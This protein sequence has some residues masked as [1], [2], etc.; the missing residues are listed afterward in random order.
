MSTD[1][2]QN[3]VKD[4]LV[5]IRSLRAEVAALKG[6][7][8]EPIA[9]VGVGCH[10]P[11]GAH[12]AEQFWQLL[13]D[14]V[15]AIS[16]LPAD[17]W[18]REAFYSPDPETPGKM[19]VRH[20][21]FIDDLATFDT[22][23]FA[24]SPREALSLDPQ[25][26]LMLRVTWEALEHAG[27]PAD[28]LRGSCTGVY[29]GTVSGEYAHRQMHHAAFDSISPY[30]LTGND[31][32]FLAGRIAHFLG[33]QGPTMVTAT[34]CSSSL[35]TVHLACQALRAG[36]CDLALAGGVSLIMDPAVNV[37]LSKMHALSPDGRCK[38]FDAAADGYGRGEGCGVVVLKRLSDAVADGDHI[39]ASLLGSA[40]N[41]DGASAGLTVPSG[42]AQVAL[43]RRVLEVGGVA[44]DEVGYVEAHG[45]G[46]ALGDPI[47]AQSIAQALGSDRSFPL[48]IGSVKTNIGHL[49]AAAGV[50]GLIKAALAVHHG[51]LPRHLHFEAPS[52]HIDWAHLPLRVPTELTPWPACYARRIAGVSSF[53]LSGVNAHVL[54]EAPVPAEAPGASDQRPSHLLPLSA[55]S[56]EALEAQRLQWADY[57]ANCPDS[58]LADVCFTAH[59]GRVHFPHRLAVVAAAAEEARAGLIG[60]VPSS[61]R[62]APRIA[63]LFPGEGPQQVRMGEELY[64]SQPIFRAVLD[65]C[66]A[67]LRRDFDTPLLD[68]LYTASG[69][70][71]P[72]ALDR[73]AAPALVALECALVELWR[74]WGIVPHAV[75]GHGVGEI[76]AAYAAGVFG[77]EEA[78]V[79]AATRARL[80]DETPS[81]GCQYAVEASEEQVAALLRQTGAAD[82]WLAS[83]NGPRSVEI[84]GAR[85][86]VGRVIADWAGLGLQATPVASHAFHSPLATRVADRFE[87]VAASLEHARPEVSLI[88]SLTGQVADD[89]LFSPGYWRQALVQPMRFWQGMLSL[90][91]L[92]IDAFVELGP[93]PVLLPLGRQCLPPPAAGDCLWLPALRSGDDWRQSLDSLGQ[94]YTR[95]ASVD[96]Q[97]FQRE[98]R[99]ARRRLA[100]PTY[101]FQ[102]D[103]YWSVG[104]E[105]ASEDRALPVASTGGAR[106]GSRLLAELQ[107]LAVAERGQVILQGL[108]R[109]V[110]L[111]LGRETLVA[112][113]CTLLELGVDSLMAAELRNWIRHEL[114]LKLGLSELLSAVTLD[115]LARTMV[116]RLCDAPQ[117]SDAEPAEGATPRDRLCPLSHGQEALW[118]VH[119]SDPLSPAYNVGVAVRLRAAL[120]VQVLR[121]AC[122]VLVR[123][124][125]A[126]R[127]TFLA[128][129]GEPFQ[130]VQESVPLHLTETD[131]RS[132]GV[133][134]LR[135]A[136]AVAYREPFDLATGPLLRLHLYRRADEYVLLFVLHHIVC[137]ALSVWSLL[138]EL[139]TVYAGCHGGAP[140]TAARLSP[141]YS[142]YVRWER[143]LLAGEEGE[144]LWSFWEQRLSGELPVL[145]LPADYPR[146]PVQ[147]LH[148]ASHIMIV[149]EELTEGLRALSRA[150]HTTLY[151]T[152][153][154]AFLTLLHRYTAQDDIIV[155]TAT[156]GRPDA[157]AGVFGY[158]ANPV[159]IRADL[160]GDPRFATFLGQVRETVL[161]AVGHQQFPFALLVERLQPRRDASRSPVFQADFALQRPPPAYRPGLQRDERDDGGII[162]GDFAVP[163]EEGQFDVSLH[164]IEGSQTLSAAFKYNADLFAPESIAGLADSYLALLEGIVKAPG[165][166]VSRL[167][168]LSE[169]QRQRLLFGYNN[170][171]ETYPDAC[172]PQLFEQQVARTPQAVAVELFR[173]GAADGER[174]AVM[175]YQELEMR[176]N[177]LARHLQSLG[178]GPEALV[179]VCLERSFN[180]VVA[181][182]GVLKAGGA[183]VPLDPTYPSE[184]LAFMMR[185]ARMSVLLT[186]ATLATSLPDL[187]GVATVRLDWDWPLIVIQPRTRPDCHLQPHHLA[188]VIYTS[189][190]TGQPKGTLITHSGFSNYLNWCIRYYRVAEGSG[191]PVNSA[192]GFDAT[193]TSMF[194][195]LLTGG[196]V[197][198]LPEEEAIEAL[199]DLLIAHRG[200]SLIKITPAHLEMLNQL[201]PADQCAGRAHSFVIGG[202]A[203]R[204]D[205]LTFWQSNAP[206]TRLINEYG[207]TETVVGCCIHDVPGPLT[208]SVPIGRP[209]AN[210]QLYVLDPH[211]QLVPPGVIG[212]LYIGGA[213]VARGYLNRPELTA[214]RFIADPFRS[215]AGGRLY[216]TGDLVRHLPDG[217]L[218]YLGRADTQVKMRGYRIELGEI[219]TVLLEHPE[220]GEASVR[221]WDDPAAGPRLVAYVVPGGATP[222]TAELRQHLARRL[223]EYMVPALFVMLDQLPLTPNGKVDRAALPPPTGHHAEAQYVAPRDPLEM[224]LTTIWEALLGVVPVG[225]RDN[226]FDSGGHSLLAVRL[227]ARIEKDI[228]VALPLASIL[229]GPT[230]EQLASI[231]RAQSPE[232]SHGPLVPIQPHGHKP[233]F[234]CVPGAG[235]NPI[236]LYSLARLLGPERPFFGLQGVGMDGE[237]APHASVEE[238]A[239][240]YLDAIREVQPTGPY[241]L[242]GHSLGGWVA[243][244][245]AQQLLRDSHEVA[246]LAI[247]DTPVPDPTQRRDTS[248]WDEARWIFELG[249][250][251]AQLL[252][253]ELGLSLETLRELDPEQQL[254]RFKDALVGASL[255]PVESDVRDLRRMLSVFKAH[256]QVGYALPAA[257][258]GTA[259]ALFRTDQ[260][261][262]A[263]GRSSDVAWGWEAIGPVE[264]HM[265]P[266]EHL[267][268]LRAPHVE[269]LASQLAG[270][271]ERAAQPFA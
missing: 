100:L 56:P 155:G 148:G 95:G 40:V 3:L 70:E 246:A 14:G 140:S 263:S 236:Y 188:Y 60:A 112:T 51:Q 251:I 72:A 87:R 106:S 116:P 104:A 23:F 196:K 147:T 102:G 144:R 163:E 89:R 53:G 218:D 123:R 207:P 105:P 265:M 245:M 117:A 209:I 28:A 239:T 252:Y 78:L 131:A 80:I 185:D 137:D 151:S 169:A 184:R 82:V 260:T 77:L 8:A 83:V 158:F 199:R 129:D 26:R 25:Q 134:E 202:E 204:G 201:L 69:P 250:R 46:T 126:L 206:E 262:S 4:A 174:P 258:P 107:A 161:E 229:R 224:R 210:T 244:E 216:R 270:Y 97:G 219:E 124:H 179:G 230:I 247:I 38:A 7:Q 181:L 2:D 220:I 149:P 10:F 16:D 71:G 99:G 37:M 205:M 141:A 133:E 84:A 175:T 118:F 33:L 52:P 166:P 167:P 195:P 168:V 152:L 257:A 182:L 31:L 138:D 41:H 24:I 248:E 32:S 237:A 111:V 231:L 108:R 172:A 76:A 198:L 154:A 130:Q 65:Q 91:K 35:V 66:D 255:F 36:E 55:A 176:A 96:W 222:S 79:L 259:A 44:A 12:S 146:P 197:V 58:D 153:L 121:E 157:F 21:G 75:M 173:P 43:L 136:A 170:T 86:A 109:Q 156:S 101:P 223:P 132:W 226:F 150:S 171:E 271:L 17:R 160:S 227:M 85:D 92:G 61:V 235:G 93:Q 54:L 62:S 128:V 63:F 119:Q 162:I 9:I 208:G 253:P 187:E 120:D 189:G 6:A 190:S 34:A 225:A 47:E 212:E 234:F 67:V 103:R 49:E 73:H 22:D 11:G 254:Q 164:I 159:P 142:D 15:D 13:K 215:V 115:E 165:Q 20:A 180:L 256:S 238:M 268:I 57:L 211:G 241:Y 42:P 19:Y 193:I 221:S 242:G 214:E 233:P 194:S 217:N 39:L 191:A 139:Q 94:L 74:S 30:M 110:G 249:D 240:C 64:G 264:V 48:L 269:V 81:E 90:V 203:L 122:E 243:F 50:A 143:E 59:T 213:G 114:G 127:T 232:S 228:G 200:F 125:P 145:S 192:I 68:L 18:D 1:A 5:K 177:Q 29:V 113:D 186:S 178:V 267:S 27:I 98:Y 183:Y 135:T 266:G 261:R 88:A 45:T